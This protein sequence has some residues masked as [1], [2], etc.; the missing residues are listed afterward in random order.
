M[1][2]PKLYRRFRAAGYSAQSA[3]HA[4]KV[5]S[6]FSDRDDVRIMADDEQENYFDVYGEPEGYVNLFVRNVTADQERDELVEQIERNGCYCVYS[7]ARDPQSGKWRVVDSVGMCVGYRDACS[8]F[9]NEHVI[10]LM[11]AAIEFAES[12][13]VGV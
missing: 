6:A 9:D 5:Y 8:P 2:I 7:Q 11:Q 12:A 1:T 10:D 13:F 3:L 4:A